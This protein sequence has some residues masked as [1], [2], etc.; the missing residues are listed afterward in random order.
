MIRSVVGHRGKSGGR[1][2]R[3]RL[4]HELA[5]AGLWAHLPSD[6]QQ[7][8]WRAV[9]AGGYPFDLDA[10]DGFVMFLMDG[11]DLAEGGVEDFLMTMR[12]GLE[13]HGISLDIDR[14]PSLDTPAEEDSYVIGINGIKC[15]ILMEEKFDSDYSWYLASV[16]PLIVVN[17][18]LDQ[19]GSA[20]RMFTLN[21]GGNDGFALLVSPMVPAAMRESGLFGDRDIPV[22]PSVDIN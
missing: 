21:A 11:E 4:A 12:A 7:A 19:S 17:K 22:Y 20:V 5:I 14:N 16:R 8:A 13:R 15:V 6:A 3:L 2:S 1:W 9:V 10:L 18:I